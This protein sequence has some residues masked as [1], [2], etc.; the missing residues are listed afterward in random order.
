VCD[1]D[2]DQQMLIHEVLTIHYG[3]S[4]GDRIVCVSTGQECLAQ[5]LESFDL[6]VQDYNLP[7]IGGLALLEQIHERA[8][9]PVIMV[10]GENNSATAIEA[11]C[12]GA[13]DYVLK[14]GDYL[15][16]L[17]VLV[18]KNIRLHRMKQDNRRLHHE[19]EAMLEELRVKN[20]QLEESLKQQETLAKTDHLTGLANRRQFN[21]ILSQY[22]EQAVRYSFDL[23]CCMCDL[24]HYKQLN[25]TLG[26]QVGDELL[27]LAAEVIRATLRSSD[28]A[29]RYGG[30]EFVLLLPHTSL[31]RGLAVGERIRQQL[32]LETRKYQQVTNPV[33]VSMG[34]ASLDADSPDS[35]DHLLCL[36]DKALYAAKQRGRNQIAMFSRMGDAATT[37]E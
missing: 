20:L 12:R 8:D 2:V 15:F 29:A 3:D 7:D 27:E 33:T 13:Q 34:I 22:Y 5:N 31:E 4:A 28:V 32:A 24:D 18:D 11:I 17:P 16:A 26:H 30:D 19:L 23:T 9:V 14:L 35:A 37:H 36:A 25:D 1:D 10:T 6:I 21:E